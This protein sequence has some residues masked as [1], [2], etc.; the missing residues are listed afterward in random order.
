MS[1][2]GPLTERGVQVVVAAG[3]A[4]LSRVRPPPDVYL[5]Q[6]INTDTLLPRCDLVCCHGGNGTLYQ[7]LAHGLPCVVVATH[8]EQH[9]GGKRIQQLGLGRALTLKQLR[10]RGMDSLVASVRQVMET[11]AYRDAARAFAPR[12]KAWEGGKLAA[13]ALEAFASA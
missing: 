1:Q 3:A 13:L 5:E 7:A 9:Y 2:L 12:L 4:D 6:Y 8:A 11:P 10:R